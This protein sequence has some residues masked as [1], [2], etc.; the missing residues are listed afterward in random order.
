MN[1]RKLIAHCLLLLAST[2]FLLASCDEGVETDFATQRGMPLPQGKYPL[3]FTAIKEGNAVQTRVTESADDPKSTLWTADRDKIGVSIGTDGAAG[4]YTIT[5]TDGSSMTEEQPVYWQNTNPATIYGWYPATTDG[6][7]KSGD[8]ID[9]RNQSSGHLKFDFMKAETQQYQ[10][11]SKDISLPFKHQMAKMNITLR[12]TDNLNL[13]GATVAIYGYMT[14]TF[15]KGNVTPG[16]SK[17]YLTACRT[18]AAKHVYRAMVVPI[19]QN[20]LGGNFIMVTLQNGNVYYY[21]SGRKLEKN[22]LYSYTVDVREILSPGD[23]AAMKNIKGTVT[24]K[25]NGSETNN[26][27]TITDNATVTL[28][29]VNIKV[30]TTGDT[31][32]TV[33]RV[34]KDKKL[35]LKVEGNDNRLEAVSGGGIVLES[36]ASIVVEGDGID[37]SKLV[38]KAGT[39]TNL[40]IGISAQASTV[41]IGAA[42]GTTCGNIEIKNVKLEV[43]GADADGGSGAAIGTSG[44][45][46]T[47]STVCGNITITN[48][49]VTATSGSGAAA[50]GTGF[51][52]IATTIEKVDD[53]TISSST[54]VATV[55]PFVSQNITDDFFGACIGLSALVDGV[56]YTCGTITI[57]CDNET[58]FLN[59]LSYKK[60]SKTPGLGYKIGKG[61]SYNCST[62]TIGARSTFNNN[63]FIDGYGSW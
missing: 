35:T 37:Q 42:C 28:K 13:D 24:I 23:A 60:G 22:M 38:V 17:G 12:S 39:N 52:Y 48:A 44:T 29:D 49:Y 56:T 18:D 30:T 55:N 45:L 14:C 27:I 5:A 11:D 8:R 33:I 6:L 41:G 53:I 2:V 1:T 63:S 46:D 50:I 51:S 7:P 15:D 59:N 34:K 10:Y 31:K 32:T 47:G 25:G 58:I 3:R 54:I 21:K 16:I 20:E 61:V 62:A 26:P 57:T 43:S 36:G 40:G 9:L 4:K 19:E